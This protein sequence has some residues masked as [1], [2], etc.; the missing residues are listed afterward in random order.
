[1]SREPSPDS[2]GDQVT[3][4]PPPAEEKPQTAAASFGMDPDSWWDFLLSG[5]IPDVLNSVFSFQPFQQTRL[6]G[7]R[8]GSGTSS[9]SLRTEG[10]Y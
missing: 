6:T 4:P 3:A 10:G 7:I 5:P 2:G 8:E 1:M 9:G